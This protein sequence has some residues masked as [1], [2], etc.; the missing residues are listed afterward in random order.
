MAAGADITRRH[1]ASCSPVAVCAQARRS[2]SRTSWE[3]KFSIIRC[4]SRTCTRRFIV[5]SAL[6]RRSF[7]TT[8][9]GRCQLP[10]VASRRGCCLHRKF[11]GFY[12]ANPSW[13]NHRPPLPE[14][15]WINNRH[16]RNNPVTL[17]RYLARH[18]NEIVVS[19][20]TGPD[21]NILR[22]RCRADSLRGINRARRSRRLVVGEGHLHRGDQRGPEGGR[23]HL[24]ADR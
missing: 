3:K 6:T 9:I 7:F 14:R 1:S 20:V 23:A 19:N 15:K 12:S 18:E 2:A 24:S 21:E 22:R 5:R 11:R 13:F 4:R 17:P 10:I 8:R 16:A